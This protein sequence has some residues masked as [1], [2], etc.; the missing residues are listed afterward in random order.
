M[1]LQTQEVPLDLLGHQPTTL[2]EE[3]LEIVCP[4]AENVLRDAIGRKICPGLILAA[5]VPIS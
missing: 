2:L 1:A 5:D 3:P 4:H